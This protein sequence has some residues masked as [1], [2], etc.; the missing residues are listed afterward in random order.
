MQYRNKEINLTKTFK[1]HHDHSPMYVRHNKSHEIFS[2]WRESTL[3]LIK[4][5]YPKIFRKAFASSLFFFELY[6]F[7]I[8][9]STL[10]L[11]INYCVRNGAKL[12]EVLEV[13]TFFLFISRKNKIE[14]Y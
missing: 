3:E 4:C 10:V 12:R 8:L 2:H 9:T 7:I 14:N 13:I 1:D 5:A 6:A 11:G